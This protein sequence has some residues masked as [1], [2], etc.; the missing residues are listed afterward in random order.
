MK[1]SFL[2]LI[3]ENEEK[4]TDVATKAFREALE[5]THLKF[6]VEMDSSGEVSS[7][8]DT[9]GGNSYHVSNNPDRSIEV[10]MTF[11]NQGFDIMSECEGFETKEEAIEWYVDE[12]AREEVERKL[13]FAKEQLEQIESMGY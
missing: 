10:L 8:Y 12:Y 2:E 1:K 11:C 6:I 13:E 3:E 5:N 7:W 9:A 4:I